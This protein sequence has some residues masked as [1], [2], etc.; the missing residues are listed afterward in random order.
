MSPVSTRGPARTSDDR[1]RRT[2]DVT[3]SLLLRSGYK[4]TTMDEIARR[5]DV[6]KGTI[7]LSWDTKDDLIRTL[8]THEIVS[9]CEEIGRLVRLRPAASRVSEFCGEIFTLVFKYPLFRALYTY[10]KETI[11]RVCDDP[12]L[13]FHPYRITGFSPFNEYLRML[14][15]HDLWNHRS[16]FSLDAVMSGFVKSHLHAEIVDPH[17]SL[18]ARATDLAHVIRS[19][20]E[21]ETWPAE[22]HADRTAAIFAQAA[23]KYRAKL[24]P[25]LPARN[26]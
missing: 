19:S 9:V 4:R 20:M 14:S 23:E 2:M 10:D 11:G 13:E 26:P 12:T 8:V 1:V 7:Y 16:D 25:T 3:R 5:A 22:P 17:P 18:D 24:I 15:E 6:G 21:P